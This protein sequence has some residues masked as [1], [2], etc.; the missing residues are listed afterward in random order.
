MQQLHP[1]K[2]RYSKAIQIP[3]RFQIEHFI[4]TVVVSW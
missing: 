4:N 2:K 3:K 1:D